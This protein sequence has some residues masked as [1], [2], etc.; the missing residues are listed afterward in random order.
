MSDYQ[1][2]AAPARAQ[3]GVTQEAVDL[4]F[5]VVAHLL[6]RRRDLFF[7][8]GSLYTIM[9][10]TDYERIVHDI[11]VG[12]IKGRLLTA[13]EVYHIMFRCNPLAP[14][15]PEDVP[16]HE[17]MRRGIPMDLTCSPDGRS[18]I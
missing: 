14:R 4:Y 18:S 2:V 12:K 13:P 11:A 10:D 6:G 5:H 17:L 16:D 9:D 1:E 7:D 8:L 15:R 3:R